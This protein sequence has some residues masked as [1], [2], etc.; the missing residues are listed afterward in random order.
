MAALSLNHVE[1]NGFHPE[2]LS[3]TALL[4]EVFHKLQLAQLDPYHVS[5]EQV[6]DAMDEL[7][8]A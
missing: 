5:E 8:G 3:H 1:A 2:C 7:F 6:R 4:E